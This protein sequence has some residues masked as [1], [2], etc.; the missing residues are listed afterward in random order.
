MCLGE[1]EIGFVPVL[2]R[3]GVSEVRKLYL[4]FSRPGVSRKSREDF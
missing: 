1:P 2:D 4:E 3:S